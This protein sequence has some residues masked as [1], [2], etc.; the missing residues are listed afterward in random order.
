MPIAYIIYIPIIL[1]ISTILLVKAKNKALVGLFLFWLFGSP[2]F[3]NPS[4]VIS[5][6]FF[7]IDIQPNRF[8]FIILTPLLYI[9]ILTPNYRITKEVLPKLNRIKLFEVFLIGFVLVVAFAMFINLSTIGS[10]LVISDITNTITFIVVYYFSKKFIK[11]D[12]AYIQIAFLSFAALSALVSTYQFFIDPEFFRLGRSYQAFS[13][14]TRSNGLFTSEYDQGLF[15]NLAIIVATS[16]NL[17]R[18]IKLSF[19]GIMCLGI[20]LTMHRLSWVAMIVTLGLVWLFY[21][22]KSLVTYLLVPL[23]SAVIIYA[24]FSVPWSQ[25]AIGKFGYNLVTDRILADTLSI[26]FSQYKFSFYM[27][28]EYPLGIGGYFTS[29]YNQEAVSQGIPLYHPAG[30]SSNVMQAYIVHNG[31]LS[32]GVK[33]G[34]TGLVLFAFFIFSSILSF[35]VNSIKKG[36]NWYPLL[37]IMVTFFIYNL[38]NDFSFLGAPINVALAWLLGGFISVTSLDQVVENTIQPI[39]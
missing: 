5:L 14:Y 20:F 32:S 13:T 18:W 30:S 25:M 24:A 15:L 17:K 1:V 4:Y 37:M 35:G 33:Y 3:L 39:C 28:R 7:G 34:I 38:T 29:F 6:N 22:R 12:F 11:D 23:V 36:K 8:L 9:S 21:L 2:I 27:M 19:V 16:M 26:R 10:R 31:I